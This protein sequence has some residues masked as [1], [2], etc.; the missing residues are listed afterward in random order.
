MNWYERRDAI[1]A[2]VDAL[3]G[4]EAVPNLPGERH[5]GRVIMPRRKYGPWHP[6]FYPTSHAEYA[7]MN[8]HFFAK[9]KKATMGLPK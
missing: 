1:M 7:A 4:F 6:G 3:P 5:I 8:R 9:H 2:L